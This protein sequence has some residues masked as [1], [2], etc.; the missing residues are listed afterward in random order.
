MIMNNSPEGTF[1]DG[2]RD[3]I[4]FRVIEVD[5]GSLKIHQVVL[6][7]DGDDIGRVGTISGVTKDDLE[8]IIEVID[9]E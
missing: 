9:N 5:A 7:E 6:N 3:N 2:T 4:G 8:S 1:V